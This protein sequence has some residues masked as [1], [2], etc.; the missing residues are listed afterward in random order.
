MPNIIIRA[1]KGVFDLAARARLAQA[2]TAVAKTVEQGGD[3]PSHSLLTWVTFDELEPGCVF[4][5]GADG[6]ARLI[7]VIVF[8]YYPAGVLDDAA[9]EEAARLFHAAICAAKPA[10]DPRPMATS[11]LMR[12][13]ADGSWGGSGEVWRLPMIA[14]AAGFK[15]LQHLTIG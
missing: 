14:K 15:H 4:V 2:L 1:P 11:V 9:R 8:F 10:D 6:L 7:P 13:M 3:D 12:E 5:G